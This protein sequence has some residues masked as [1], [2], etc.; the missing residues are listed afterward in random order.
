MTEFALSEIDEKTLE[1]EKG[2]TLMSVLNRTLWDVTEKPT[3]ENII[4]FSPDYSIRY[5]PE[6]VGKLI[7]VHY[8]S[9]VPGITEMSI[10]F[11]VF[12]EWD[13]YSSGRLF[14]APITIISILEEVYKFYNQDKY[15]YEKDEKIRFNIN[16][17]G[18]QKYRNFL[19]KKAEK[20]KNDFTIGSVLVHRTIFSGINRFGPREAIST[21]YIVNLAMRFFE[22]V[23]YP[24]HEQDTRRFV[25]KIIEEE[26]EK[27]GLEGERGYRRGEG[28]FR[29]RGR[30][31]GRY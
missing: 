9:R 3:K 21:F 12:P 19:V 18:D 11:P 24:Y 17:V 26:K 22:P 14:R 16:S 2:R 5:S 6:E 15:N 8:E 29:R 10:V 27:R 13:T 30:G 4:I 25:K 20:M 7:N 1:D 28:E 31:R 23:L